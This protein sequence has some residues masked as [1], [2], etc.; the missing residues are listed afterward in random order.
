MLAPQPL[1]KTAAFP[2]PFPPE[3]ALNT[4][5]LRKLS[6]QLMPST[7]PCLTTVATDPDAISYVPGHPW[8]ELSGD[9]VARFLQSELA[10]PILD[11]LYSFLWIFSRPSFDNIDPLHRQKMKNRKI[12]PIQN[13]NLHLV[14]KNDGIYV[15][16]MPVWMLNDDFWITFL[17][18]P[19]KAPLLPDRDSK[20]HPATDR[21]TALGFVRSYAFLVQDELDFKLAQA[22]YLIPPDI[23]WIEWAIFM[24]YFRNLEDSQVSARYHFG[25]LR[26]SRLNWAVRLLRPKSARTWWFYEVPYWAISVYLQAALSPFLFI[27]GSVSVVLSSMQVMAA[28]EDSSLDGS[29]LTAMKYSFW[30][31]SMVTV[32][33]SAIVWALA[34]CIPLFVLLHQFGWGVLNR[35]K[36]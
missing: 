1:G 4:E 23:Q 28:F 35:I 11:E 30:M 22:D 26:I 31:F 15:K 14:W 17:S 25:Q 5:K 3:H 32:V 33:G 18:S 21:S 16:P 13:P 12:I 34:I 36:M 24:S 20:A 2:A 19:H 10:T 7:S 9:S 29:Q 8:V 6:P 27:F